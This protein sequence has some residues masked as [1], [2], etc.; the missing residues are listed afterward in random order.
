MI[1]DHFDAIHHHFS[2][3]QYNQHQIGYQ[4]T[5][6]N[7]EEFEKAH[8]AFIGIQDSNFQKECTLIREELYE[9]YFAKNKPVMYDLGNFSLLDKEQFSFEQLA[10]VIAELLE[11]NILP[12]VFGGSQKVMYSLQKAFAK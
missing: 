10:E 1:F 11:R 9:L 5:S 7:E 12:V 3:R 4:L 2:D 8:V 6:Q